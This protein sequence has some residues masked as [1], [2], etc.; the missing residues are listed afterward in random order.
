MEVERLNQLWSVYYTRG[1]QGDLKAAELAL[2]I[3]IRRA[4]VQGL[5]APIRHQ[6]SGDDAGPPVV[7]QIVETAVDRIDP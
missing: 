6:H 4:A 2:K 1:L 7:L 5:D 3:A